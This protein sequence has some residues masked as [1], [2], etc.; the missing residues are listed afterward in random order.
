MYTCTYIH[1]HVHVCRDRD[2]IT[3][4]STHSCICTGQYACTHYR[5]TVDRASRSQCSTVPSTWQPWPCSSRQCGFSP[6]LTPHLPLLPESAQWLPDHRDTG[7]IH[8][9]IHVFA[10]CSFS[11]MYVYI[12]HTC[13][14]IITLYPIPS[15]H[16]NMQGLISKGRPVEYKH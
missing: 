3:Y 1:V 8:T 9:H 10:K 6:S 5:H 11:D 2:T 14:C 4:T 15:L 13:T 7:H 12:L 16:T